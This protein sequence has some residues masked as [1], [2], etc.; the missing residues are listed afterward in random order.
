MA[1]KVLFQPPV[2]GDSAA[3]VVDRP[4]DDVSDVALDAT[5]HNSA[6]EAVTGGADAIERIVQE[7][8]AAPFSARLREQ[9]LKCAEASIRRLFEVQYITQEDAEGILGSFG[10]YVNDLPDKTSVLDIV[11]FL[12][13]IKLESKEEKAV[14]EI[15]QITDVLKATLKEKVNHIG[16]AHLTEMPGNL[17]HDHDRIFEICSTLMC[18][19]IQNNETDFFTIASI[20]PI[21]AATAGA[22]VAQE[23]ERATGTKPF[24]FV[25]TTDSSAWSF[26]CE[27]HFGS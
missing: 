22:L 23:L 24:S 17:Y 7:E 27:K 20:N 2:G 12:V 25:M 11:A 19:V 5:E 3:A 18:P 13:T 6:A 15:R 4:A 10:Y 8:G 9:T 21:T 1:R 14:K 16:F 26:L